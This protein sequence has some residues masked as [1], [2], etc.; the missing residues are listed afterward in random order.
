MFIIWY[1]FSALKNVYFIYLQFWMELM[2][3]ENLYTLYDY[4]V[5]LSVS[6]L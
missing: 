3:F 5:C 6:H 2:E 1:S 4:C